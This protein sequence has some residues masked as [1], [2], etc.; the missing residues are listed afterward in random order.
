MLAKGAITTLGM[1]EL[2]GAE[3]DDD[4]IGTLDLA[5]DEE[6]IRHFLCGNLCG[7]TG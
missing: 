1:A 2:A 3:T 6:T 7:S 5:P 4:T